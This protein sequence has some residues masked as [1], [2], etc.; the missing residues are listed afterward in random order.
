[1]T[2][3]TARFLKSQGSAIAQDIVAHI[4]KSEASDEAKRIV[5]DIDLTGWS[6][7]V[8]DID[9]FLSSAGYDGAKMAYLQ[10][11]AIPDDESIV[12]TS[13]AGTALYARNRAAELVGKKW[14]K[15]QLVDNPNAKWVI[16]DYTREMLQDLVTKAIEEGWSNDRL[17]DEIESN[18]AF[19]RRRA[20]TIARTEIKKADSMGSLEAYKAS[21]IVRGKES[22]LSN[23]HDHDDEC[24]DNADAGV[25][26]IDEAFP[27]G[28]DAPPYHPNCDCSIVPALIGADE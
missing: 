28:D 26:G 19:S 3:Y 15:G 13:D 7:I 4:A 20:N 23:D 21:G 24:N 27:S 12:S 22:L 16:T 5:D 17:T 25:I 9:D 14:V 1:M 8:G 6:V 2:A 18:Y 11:G 10:L